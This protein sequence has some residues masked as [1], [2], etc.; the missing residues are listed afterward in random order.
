MKTQIHKRLQAGF[1]LYELL[2]TVII[3]GVVLSYGIANMAD[4]TR[5]NRMT[6]TVNDLHAAFH[7]ARSESARART[8]VT[9]CASSNSMDENP[10][11]TGIDTWD[12]GYIVFQDTD[13]DLL[14]G[15]D[16]TILRR[17]GEAETGI[18]LTFENDADYFSYSG[19]GQGRGDVDGFPAVSRV[20]MCD[21]RGNTI[22]AGGNSAARLFVVTP[23]GRGTIVRDLDRIQAAMD[24]FPVWCPT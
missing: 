12:R 16:E 24:D 14:P 9:I 13:G 11:C 10:T 23:M 8:N 7:L 1:T 17:Q 3:V 22:G 21:K 2:I 19:T 5:N 4:F 6:A 15:F 18:R 20:V